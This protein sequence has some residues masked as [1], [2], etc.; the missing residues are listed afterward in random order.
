VSLDAITNNGL[1]LCAYTRLH[2]RNIINPYHS[3][4]R[5]DTVY[6][7]FARGMG[8]MEDGT[9]PIRLGRPSPGIRK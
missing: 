1:C 3:N 4:I 9:P 7:L 8:H 6:C 5:E 2:S